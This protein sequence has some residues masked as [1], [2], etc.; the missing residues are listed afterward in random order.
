MNRIPFAF[1]AI[2]FATAAARAVTPVSG[3]AM[4]GPSAAAVPAANAKAGTAPATGV[5]ALPMR[6][7]KVPL[8]NVMR[9]MSA[10]YGVPFTIEANAVAPISGDFRSLDLKA[11][12][13]EVARQ[14]GLFAIPMGKE[15]SAGFCLSLHPPAAPNP[16]APAPSAA[17]AASLAA[18]PSAAPAATDPER[19]R[20]E[21]LQQRAR[22]L[23]AAAHQDP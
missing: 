21:L 12:V 11:T 2:F 1:A 15:D 14:A 7:S 3:A 22:L 19:R 10:R 23:A 6:F 20:A 5:S 16:I 9:V 17:A 8:G 4:P 13:A 18:S